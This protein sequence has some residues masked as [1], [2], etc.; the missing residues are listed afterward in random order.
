MLTSMASDLTP[1]Y[2]DGPWT[3]RE[4]S[5]NGARFHVAE[6]G[7]GPLALFLHGFPQFWWT[8]RN[9]LTAFAEAGYRAVAMD[10]RGVGGSDKP[11]RGYDPLTLTMDVTGVIRALGESNA[12]LIGHGWGAG[13]AWTAA[14][15]RPKAVRR[16]VIVG[17]AHPRQTR[18]SLLTSP[19]QIA[20]SKHIFAA[21]RPLQAERGLVKDHGAAVA[22]MLEAW[23][24]PGWPEPEVSRRYQDAMLIPGVA[25]STM[26][27]YRWQLRSLMRPDG[28]RY[29]QRMRA[30]TE[31]PTL[32]LHGALDTVVLDSTARGSGGQVNAPYRWR[33]L[34]GIGHFPQE[35]APKLFTGE[36]LGWLR[37]EEPDR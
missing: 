36:V 24:G 31:V 14:T 12:V 16:L 33:L 8:W 4:V 17:A 30:L 37:D 19:G 7:D 21:Q 5:A 13:L 28:L 18:A 22:R 29:H 32:H 11:P 15:M 23:S 27:Y 1:V 25:H 6:V 10:L 26:E 9:Q 34:E 35:E 2:A 20:A 3:H